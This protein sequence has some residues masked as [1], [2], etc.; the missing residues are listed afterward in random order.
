[1]LFV[2]AVLLAIFVLPRPW[3]VVAMVVAG[4]IEVAESGA[5]VWWTRRR[6]ARVGIETL[7]GRTA[8]AMSE[9][10]SSGQVRIDGEIWG[11]RS[12]ASVA[13]GEEVVVTA[14]DGLTLVVEPART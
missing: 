5:L 12:D 14:V 8:V 10:A 2:L 13:R 3:G 4:V 11:A 1:V 9:V 7:V 6:K